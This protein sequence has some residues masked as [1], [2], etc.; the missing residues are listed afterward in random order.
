[1][2]INVAD[3]YPVVLK[4][5]WRATDHT[6]RQRRYCD[7][8]GKQT[9]HQRLQTSGGEY[10]VCS[11]TGQMV[12]QQFPTSTQNAQLYDQWWKQCADDPPDPK[13]NARKRRWVRQFEPY[14]QTGLLLE[15]GSGL[16]RL[17][18]A[19]IQEGWQAHGNEV[20]PFAAEH[21]H[22]TT[23]APVLVGPI[24]EIDLEP[25]AYDV[26]I[27]NNVF[28]HLHKPMGTL[29]KLVNALRPGGALYLQTLSGQSLSLWVQ[30]RHW[31]YFNPGHLYVPTLVS[32]AHY[33]AATGVTPR[34]TVT[35]GCRTGQSDKYAS[36]GWGRRRLDK[37]LSNLAGRLRLGHRVE[38]VLRKSG[39]PPLS[40]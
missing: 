21:A 9:E 10:W 40:R 32:L 26:I 39:S 36:R 34:S 25:T 11:Q 7:A 4:R 28:E 15:I 6:T 27:C 33:F 23:G 16:G 5:A 18:Q 8:L 24:E 38:F 29:Q 35:H 22:Q 12:R 1:M 17:L 13:D 19:A 30:P 2:S 14:R 3:S 20:S 37:L 31:I